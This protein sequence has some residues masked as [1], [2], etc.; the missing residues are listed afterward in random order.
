MRKRSLDVHACIACCW[1]ITVKHMVHCHSRLATKKAYHGKSFGWTRRWMAENGN[2]YFQLWV[3]IT[4]SLLLVSRDSTN[5]CMYSLCMFFDLQQ[6]MCMLHIQA[7]AYERVP[8]SFW[9]KLRTKQYNKGILLQTIRLSAC[10]HVHAASFKYSVL[11]WPWI[12][13]LPVF[14]T[15]RRVPWALKPTSSFHHQALLTLPNTL[16]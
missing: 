1:K 6:D 16:L 5:K 15:E 14:C 4:K 2:H 9:H 12:V 7:E 8:I 10:E 3:C 11:K 13:A